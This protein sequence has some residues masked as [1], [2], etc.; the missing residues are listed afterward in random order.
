MILLPARAHAGAAPDGDADSAHAGSASDYRISVRKYDFGTAPV[1]GLHSFASGV[2]DGKWVILSG[3]TN[4]VHEI[5]QAGTGSFPAESQNRDIWVIDPIAKQTWH[6]SMGQADA[7]GVDPA[8]GLTP[9][10]VASLA[11]TNNR[12][13]ASWKHAVRRRW[14][15]LEH[16]RRVRNV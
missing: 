9:A 6:R 1:A 15:R 5:D 11:A 14:L 16:Y 10:Q 13:P 8:S 4:G 3:R 2:V 12:V 7:T